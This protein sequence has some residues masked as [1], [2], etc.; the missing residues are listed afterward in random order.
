MLNPT[1]IALIIILVF[2]CILIY[3]KSREK[4]EN[5]ILEINASKADIQNPV[6]NMNLDVRTIMASE[7][8]IPNPYV[9]PPFGSSP[10]D[11]KQLEAKD[12]S[13]Y[14][15]SYNLVSPACCTV[16]W[17]V[18]FKL[19]SDPLVCAQKDKFVPN[20][21]MG[22][23]NFQNAGCMCATKEQI[24]FLRSRGGNAK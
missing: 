1:N 23:N 13:Y 14:D 15:L 16:Q 5:S 11:M 3:Y 21:Y 8:F 2:L 10:E 6:K 20:Q 7:D 4:Y 24:D 9:I 18:P 17:P 19:D 12:G 22:N